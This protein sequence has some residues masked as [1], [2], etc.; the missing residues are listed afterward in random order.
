MLSIT[1]L[2]KNILPLDRLMIGHYFYG[3]ELL[4]LT[5]PIFSPYWQETIL[6][7]GLGERDISQRA[8]K[9]HL[10]PH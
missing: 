10:S 8:R 4:P 5:A 1:P 6:C 2:F 3:L 9:K 7:S